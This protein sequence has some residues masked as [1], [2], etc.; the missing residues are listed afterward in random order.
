MSIR[1]RGAP[2]ELRLGFNN[3]F[4]LLASAVVR[5]GGFLKMRAIILKW[6]GILLGA[7]VGIGLAVLIQPKPGAA[8]AG[9]KDRRQGGPY[10]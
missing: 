4:G 6:T 2:P 8:P 3:L 7:V 10:R 9:L 1:Y 5:P